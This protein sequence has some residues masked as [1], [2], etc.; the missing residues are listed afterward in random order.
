LQPL[1]FI[2]LGGAG[3]KTIR[4]IKQELLRLIEMAGWANKIPEAWQFLHIDFAIDGVEFPAPMLAQ[5]ETHL[6]LPRGTTFNNTS[7]ILESAGSFSEL[8]EMLAGWVEPGLAV[9]INSSPS[10]ERRKGRQGFM[11]GAGGTHTAISESIGRM[12]SPQAQSELQMISKKSGGSLKSTPH[13]LIFSSLVGGTGSGML[14]DVSEILRL[15]F[16]APQITT[17]LFAPEVFESLGHLITSGSGNVLGA[18]NEITASRIVEIS[19]ETKLL[20]GKLAI[21]LNRF[22]GIQEF[23]SSRNIIIGCRNMAGVDLSVG[24]YSSGYQVFL[25]T[26]K[27]LGGIVTDERVSDNFFNKLP[28]IRSVAEPRDASGLSPESNSKPINAASAIGMSKL[29]VG[30]ERLIDYVADALTRAQVTKLLWPKLSG[31]PE[32]LTQ[33]ETV[34]EIISKKSEERLN[35]LLGRTGLFAKQIAETYFPAGWN[36]HATAIDLVENCVSTNSTS[37]DQLLSGVAEQLQSEHPYYLDKF[38]LQINQN[39]RQWIVDIQ[40]TMKIVIEEEVVSGGLLV[41]TKVLEMLCSELESIT[42]NCEELFDLAFKSINEFSR[43]DL[44]M[45]VKNLVKDPSRVSKDDSALINSIGVYVSEFINFGCKEMLLNIVDDLVKDFYRAFLVNIIGSL[46]KA[47][48]ILEWETS[49]N[50]DF[51]LDSL[52]MW[53]C[54]KIPRDYLPLPNERSLI[55]ASD[56][57]AIFNSCFAEEGAAAFEESISQSLLAGHD[58]TSTDAKLSLRWLEAKNPWISENPEFRNLEEVSSMAHWKFEFNLNEIALHNRRWLWM[59]GSP[60]RQKLTLSIRSFIEDC[61]SPV[62]RAKRES[63]FIYE[64]DA[65]L[66]SAAPFATLNA[67]SFESLKTFSE[68]QSADRLIYSVSKLPF[69]VDSPI[70]RESLK[71]LRHYGIDVMQPGVLADCFDQYSN[72]SALF[73]LSSTY[74]ALP[75]WA[76]KSLTSPVL[77]KSAVARNDN[78]SWENFWRGRRTRPL[79]EAIPFETQIRQS[80][81]TGWFVSRIFGLSKLKKDPVQTREGVGRSV[82]IWN[83]TLQIPDWS[84][85]PSPLLATHRRDMQHEYWVLPQLLTSA[86]LAFAMFGETGDPSHLYGYRLLKY[87]GREVTAF[88]HRDTWDGNGVGDLL[89]NGSRSQSSYIQKW[90]ETGVTHAPSPKLLPALVERLKENSDRKSALIKTLQQFRVQYSEAWK[91]CETLKWYEL[92][93]TWELRKEIDLALADIEDYVSRISPIKNTS[94]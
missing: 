87:L 59:E 79:K 14:L 11:A 30:T 41:T 23:G 40:K 4:A 84:T 47:S 83:P 53:G 10:Q 71:I 78:A 35:R 25:W 73:A 56:F 39:A 45:R 72:T 63:K 8:Q 92:P 74:S 55:E 82:E 48:D 1:L 70:G 66:G 43:P 12:S 90:L 42:K 76:F 31:S 81:I 32:L 93:E 51:K 58:T 54:G 57:E 6:I 17:I 67:R 52:P 22:S 24:G 18:M 61:D 37:L 64:L 65:L 16:L 75:F 91:R 62:E 2:G 49:L 33:S 28:D 60:L 88:E 68:N 13:V 94:I 15:N 85:F 69:D 26:G 34:L 20:Y 21:G 44:E 27:M 89:P 19:D 46:K 9:N 29:T 50:R 3:G 80:I 36:S 7:K 38:R 77:M 86:G 5:N